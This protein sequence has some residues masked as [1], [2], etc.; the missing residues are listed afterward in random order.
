MLTT[1]R[2]AS[3]ASSVMWRNGLRYVHQ[4]QLSAACDGRCHTSHQRSSLRRAKTAGVVVRRL[5]HQCRETLHFM[6]VDL[7]SRRAGTRQEL[8]LQQI[9]SCDRCRVSVSF[10]ARGDEGEEG[11]RILAIEQ[12]VRRRRK[13]AHVHPRR[14]F[15]W[16]RARGRLC[17]PVEL[18]AQE[19]ACVLRYGA[20]LGR[21]KLSGVGDG[22]TENILASESGHEKQKPHIEY[23]HGR[24]LLVRRRRHT[25]CARFGLE[26]P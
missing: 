6:Q 18:V 12:E 5:V 1:P 14:D 24:G 11:P 15:S 13:E 4:I 20:S 26:V 22:V 19:G 25:A 8:V 2:M 21:R 16:N 17:L 23:I 7:W 10:Q 3:R 9:A